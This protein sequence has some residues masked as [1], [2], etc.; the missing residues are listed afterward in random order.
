M[1]AQVHFACGERAPWERLCEGLAQC[2]VCNRIG[3]YFLLWL[4][5]SVV[6]NWLSLGNEVLSWAALCSFVVLLQKKEKET[7]FWSVATVPAES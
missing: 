3:L 5:C 1:A 4:G 7:L 2:S 6:V